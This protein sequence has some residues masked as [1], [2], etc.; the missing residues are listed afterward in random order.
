VQKYFVLLILTDGDISDKKETIAEIVKASTLPLSIVIVG[1][2]NEDFAAM[3]ALASDK[4]ALK[5]EKT[6]NYSARNIVQCVPYNLVRHSPILLARQ[7]LA[8]IPRQVTEFMATYQF[9]PNPRIVVTDTFT[10]GESV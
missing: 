6:G 7:T 5:D 8:E 2:G 9:T 1:I 10:H 3:E 4:K